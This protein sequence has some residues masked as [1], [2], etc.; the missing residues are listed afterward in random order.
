MI[1]RDKKEVTNL[2]VQEDFTLLTQN[3][4]KMYSKYI[5]MRNYNKERGIQGVHKI[6]EGSEKNLQEK[7][8]EDNS[9]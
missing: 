4:E 2:E 8:K 1:E 9:A 6:D 3:C 5:V 7:E